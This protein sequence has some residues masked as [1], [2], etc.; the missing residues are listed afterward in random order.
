MGI[1]SSRSFTMSADAIRE[2]LNRR[3]FTPFQMTLSSGQTIEVRHPEFVILTRNGM[4]VA[5]PDSDRI[6]ICAFLHIAGVETQ[7]APHAA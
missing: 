6:S 1:K 4:V 3:P 7:A 5:Y 2:L